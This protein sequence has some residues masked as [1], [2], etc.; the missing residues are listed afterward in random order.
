MLI[1]R[2]ALPSPRG[3]AQ[4]HL[5]MLLLLAQD[6][7][8]SI[9]ASGDA[10]IAALLRSPPFDS[11]RSTREGRGRWSARVF[12]TG[13]AG[14]R[15]GRSQPSPEARARSERPRAAKGGRPGF[16]RRARGVAR[17]DA[18]GLSATR[19]A[20][21]GRA[22]AG[23]GAAVLK[24]HQ[25]GAPS[26]PHPTGGRPEAAL[27]G[28]LD[29]TRADPTRG[30]PTPFSGTLRTAPADRR[31]LLGRRDREVRDA[32]RRFSARTRRVALSPLL[33]RRSGR[34]LDR[35]PGGLIG[36]DVKQ[37]ALLAR[38]SAPAWSISGRFPPDRS[39]A[40]RRQW[41]PPP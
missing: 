16:R 26:R 29:A 13:R 7:D 18:T 6:R 20:W 41:T 30:A 19:G 12:R 38:A 33:E 14:R 28:P 10:L 3:A 35:P 1:F 23:P 37:S 27:R 2:G 36:P 32:E 40:V 34:P 5:R 22:I 17:R 8:F 25:R 39:E 31:R 21:R 9:K 11:G 15:R 4:K 24:G